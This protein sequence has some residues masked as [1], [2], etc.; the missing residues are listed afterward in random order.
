MNLNSWPF[1]FLFRR[2]FLFLIFTEREKNHGCALYFTVFNLSIV[3]ESLCVM[4]GVCINR[5]IIDLLRILISIPFNAKIQTINGKP[6]INPFCYR[7]LQQNA[8]SNC[9][10]KQI[11]PNFHKKHIQQQRKKNEGKICKHSGIDICMVFTIC[12]QKQQN[13]CLY[14]TR[15]DNKSH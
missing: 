14:I 5:F 11:I 1:G 12:D 4:F 9:I 6:H 7:F 13:C 15:I 8:I 2:H 3:Y 10:V